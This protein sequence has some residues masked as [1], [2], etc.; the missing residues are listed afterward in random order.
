[1]LNIKTTNFEGPL[2][3]LLQL[4]EKNELEINQ[5]SLSEVTE[6][7]LE[8]L[9]QVE[10]KE[11]EKLADFLV[12][13]SKLI[14]LKSKTLLPNLDLEEDGEVDELEKQ[15]KLYRKFITATEL[16]QDRLMNR[17]FSFAKDKISFDIDH[18][19]NPPKNIYIQDLRKIFTEVVARLEP[20]VKL[21]ERSL[22]RAISIK[23]KINQLREL[24][25]QKMSTNFSELVQGSASRVEI[26]VTFLGLL[27]LV[28]QRFIVLE[29]DNLFQ[30]IEIKKIL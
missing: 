26:V 8:Y 2:E 25:S 3:L 18:L 21:P 15:L 14:Y 17:N 13:A 20:I 30:E 10:Q 23:H 27:E 7:Y 24:I 29:Q 9:S 22:K 4:I 6:Q 19:F 12:V 11:P 16:M 1:M 28:K 5:I